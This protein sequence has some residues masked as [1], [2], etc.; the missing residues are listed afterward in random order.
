MQQKPVTSLA[1]GS[2][3]GLTGQQQHRPASLTAGST[4]VSPSQP[5]TSLHRASTAPAGGAPCTDRITGPQPVDV[6]PYP[7]PR[8]NPHK[9]YD[10]IYSNLE[11][12][13]NSILSSIVCFDYLSPASPSL[14]SP[15]RLFRTQRMRRPFASTPIMNVRCYTF[16]LFLFFFISLVISYFEI[17][18]V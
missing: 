17:R 6:S 9:T 1:A 12:S 18:P 14:A 13:P 4:M 5:A 10:I 3:A 11:Y 15:S 8:T 7:R 2:P 16:F